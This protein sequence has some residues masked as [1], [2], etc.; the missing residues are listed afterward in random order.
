LLYSSA[1]G[2][3]YYKD[4]NAYQK[5]HINFNTGLSARV[6]GRDG[7][8]WIIGP[9]ISFDLN[10]LIRQDNQQYLMFGGVSARFLLPQKKK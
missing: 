2:G 6:H 10:R 5:L 7:G 3:V 1:L 8:E 9:E 4:K